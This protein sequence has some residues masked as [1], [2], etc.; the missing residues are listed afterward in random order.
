MTLQE[1]VRK[2]PALYLGGVDAEG[3]HRL[4]WGV[5]GWSI[6]QHLGRRVTSVAV[7][8]RGTVFSVEDDGPGLGA[9]LSGTAHT[10]SSI[11]R[12]RLI[13]DS[14]PDEARD[15]PNVH[16]GAG[17]APLSLAM[18]NALCS[19]FHVTSTVDGYRWR[20]TFARGRPVTRVLRVGRAANQGTRFRLVPDPEIFSELS[21]NTEVIG[22]RL[23]QFAF[24]NPLARLTLQGARLRGY[25]GLAQWLAT[26]SSEATCRYETYQFHDNVSVDLAVV[27]TPRR[28]TVL[29]AFVNQELCD[30]G[31]HIDGLW[32]GLKAWAQT[33]LGREV[34]VGSVRDSLA[35]GMA[36]ILNVNLVDPRFSGA[37]RRT[38]G[39]LVARSAVRNALI[40]DTRFRLA[41][42]R[43]LQAF[44]RRRLGWRKSSR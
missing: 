31:A 1:E 26:E 23:Q 21:W 34:G 37:G 4:A 24:L 20:Q 8:L 27:W 6:D 30:S 11:F 38:L 32:L 2:R 13:R 41:D 33:V 44:L 42:D 40:A 5:V 43:G 25:G 19:Q 28:H 22:S 39:S 29:R 9:G 15:F 10:A 16:V 3:L 14:W 18:V 12:R 35:P 17:R 36:A 7:D